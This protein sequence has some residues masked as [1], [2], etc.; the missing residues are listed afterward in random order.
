[1]PID[2][3][4]DAARELSSD[5]L[6]G[7]PTAAGVAPGRVEVLG[8]HTDYNDGYVLAAAIDRH[9][10]VAGRPRADGAARVYSAA[11]DA[12]AGFD[13]NAPARTPRAP[14]LDYVA[15]VAHELGRAGAPVSGFEAVISGDLPRDAGLS[16]SAALEVAAARFLLELFPFDL[17]PGDLARLCQRAEN[18]FVGV[19]CGILDQW[20]CVHGVADA[21][22]LLDCRELAHE[23][24]PLGGAALVIADT[25]APRRLADGG[26][27]RL[28]ADCLAAAQA[29]AAHVAGATHLRDIPLSVLEAHEHELSADQARRARHVL[30]ENDRVLRGAQALRARKPAALGALMRESHASSR[31]LFGNS[32]P[33]LDAMVRSARDLPGCYG[34]RLSGG[35]FGGSTVNLVGARAAEAFAPALARAYRAR[36]RIAPAVHVCRAAAGARGIRL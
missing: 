15:G 18:E 20:T 34:A 5:R 1:M 10:V 31:E 36:T 8:N 35:G 3:L 14:W 23:A 29:L 17:A 27:E 16:S 9:V 11:F 6:G 13:V 25:H 26:Y 24:I 7:P 33:E 22:L 12:Q 30:L 4:L 19:P 32:S 28:R 21:A 2:T